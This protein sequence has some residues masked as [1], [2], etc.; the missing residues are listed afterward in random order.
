MDGKREYLNKPPADADVEA[1]CDSC[2]HRG[3]LCGPPPCNYAP[4]QPADMIS[5]N[6]QKRV[7]FARNYAQSIKS[8]GSVDQPPADADA[9]VDGLIADLQAKCKGHPNALIP[10]PHRL[11]HRAI[12]ALRAKYQLPADAE[13][14]EALRSAKEAQPYFVNPALVLVDEKCLRTLLSYVRAVQQP[15]M[16]EEQ[17]EAV[18]DALSYLDWH[19][20]F[21]R[22]KALRSAFPALFVKEG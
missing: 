4:K 1:D 22:A 19:D 18:K 21:G 3:K 15:K 7:Q 17:V 2:I 10:W 9:D 16:A 20:E 5:R 11:L 8:F 6:K 14:R 12:D 13:V